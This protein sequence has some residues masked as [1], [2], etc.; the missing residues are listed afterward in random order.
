MSKRVFLKGVGIFPLL[1]CVSSMTLWG[2]VLS[3]DNPAT[4]QRGDGAF[5][6]TSAFIAS[7]PVSVKEFFGDKWN[8][9][10]TP[11]NGTNLVM[12]SARSEIGGNY[13][14]WHIGYVHRLETMIEASRDFVDLFDSIKHSEDLIV[15]R[16]YDLNLKINGFQAD[17][18]HVAKS[19]PLY[20][21]NDLNIRGGI[22]LS[23]LRGIRMQQ[24]VIDGTATALAGKDYSYAGVVDYYYT[25]NYLYDLDLNLPTGYGF[26]PD[27]G[28][29]GDWGNWHS[30]LVVNDLF[31]FMQWNNAPYT[32]AIIS[33]NTKHYDSNGYVQY[34]PTITGLETTR[35]FTQHFDPKG[36]A[37]LRYN[38]SVFSPFV[39]ASTTRGYLFPEGGV[40][41]TLANVPTIKVSYETFFHS[42]GLALTSHYGY[43]RFQTDKINPDKA[44]T[45]SLAFGIHYAY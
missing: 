5:M 10:Y 38:S 22:G 8:G 3:I 37:S 19:I 21:G 1:V 28:V 16:Q 30:D 41:V 39:E 18:L 45:L 29:I 11:R 31:G 13:K 27:I 33:S 32:N 2:D 12:A 20:S 23:L 15:G 25:S 4:V 17:G 40:L 42:Y 44:S 34:S 7:D 14:G 36:F 9:D 35:K 24:G 43:I 26:S 6:S